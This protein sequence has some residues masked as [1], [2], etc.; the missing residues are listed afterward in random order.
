MSTASNTEITNSGWSIILTPGTDDNIELA[1]SGTGIVDISGTTAAGAG[2]GALICDGGGYFAVGNYVDR[3]AASNAGEFRDGA[4]YA[5]LAST[6]YAASFAFGTEQV[7]ICDG[8]DAI[9]ANSGRINSADGFS[10]NGILG[11]TI[12]NWTGGGIVTGT[13]IVEIDASDL[14]ATDKILVRR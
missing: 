12:T 6:S 1:T 10:F 9:S 7:D 8:F 5:R 14:R 3:G 13:D 11:V 2:A 4:T